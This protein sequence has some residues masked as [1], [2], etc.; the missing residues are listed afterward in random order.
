VYTAVI[1]FLSVYVKEE[2]EMIKTT[3]DL[4]H[5][6]LKNE[7]DCRNSDNILY[8]RV[9]QTIGKQNGIDINNMSVPTLFH[10]MSAMKFPAF[11]TVRR[12]RQKVQECNPELRATDTVEAYRT[13]LEEEY[14]DY[15]RRH[16]V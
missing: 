13:V 14:K 12:T 3:S 6:I 5:E 4:V 2:I 15:A 7:P 1:Q 9:I 10:N 8:L 11:E 16:V